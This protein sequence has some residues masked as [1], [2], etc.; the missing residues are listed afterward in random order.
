MKKYL[1]YTIL[2]C[3]MT[4]LFDI[5]VTACPNCKDSFTNGPEAAIGESY[6][7]SILFMLGMFMSVIGGFSL[8]V[9]TNIRKTK[10]KV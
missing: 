9:W 2:I 10:L 4:M 8:L 5:T 6:S 3:I 7:W 1:G